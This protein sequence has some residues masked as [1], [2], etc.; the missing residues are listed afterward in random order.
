MFLAYVVHTL[1]PWYQRLEQRIDAN[2]LTD[3]DRKNGLY[4]CFVEEGLLR[5]SLRDTKDTILGY[6]NGGILTPN[7]GRA[8][9][10]ANPDPDPNSDKLRIP[11]T[12]T[13]DVPEPTP[14]PTGGS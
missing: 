5:G 4:S 14:E 12:V 9:L 3:R 13:T 10:D 6:V 1:A 2:L 7:E 11:S 8:K